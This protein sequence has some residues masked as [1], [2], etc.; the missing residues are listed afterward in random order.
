MPREWLTRP[1]STPPKERPRHWLA[2]PAEATALPGAAGPG[3][4]LLGTGTGTALHRHRGC[5]TSGSPIVTSL[6]PPVTL[7]SPSATAPLTYAATASCATALAVSQTASLLP[8]HA[9]TTPGAMSARREARA[10][11]SPSAVIPSAKRPIRAR[12][13]SETATSP[14]AKDPV[15]ARDRCG[16]LAMPM[17]KDPTVR[18]PLPDRVVIPSANEPMGVRTMPC[19]GSPDRGWTV[20]LS[21]PTSAGR[22]VTALV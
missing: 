15:R 9:G 20:S 18:T 22:R 16:C 7:R 5:R 19:S 3:T 12:T 10:S 4:G 17:A 13:R 8:S 2:L 1:G 11:P 14:S 6:T 21:G